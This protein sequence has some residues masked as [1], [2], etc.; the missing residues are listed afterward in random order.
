MAF[1]SLKPTM[2]RF[3][4]LMITALLAGCASQ[5]TKPDYNPLI[6]A[7]ISQDRSTII[8]TRETYPLSVKNN[9][10]LTCIY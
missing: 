7:L 2:R 1:Y 9:T 6:N 10:L 3:I 5:P 8:A 4:L